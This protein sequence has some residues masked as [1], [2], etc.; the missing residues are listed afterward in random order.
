MNWETG[1]KRGPFT[2]TQIKQLA[3]LMPGL[4][5]GQVQW[6]SGYLTGIGPLL[7]EIESSPEII[8]EIHREFT[9]SKPEPVWILYGTHTGNSERLAKESEKRIAEIGIEARVF[10]MGAF[11]LRDLKNIKRL[12]IIVST[13]GE[14]DPPVQAGDLLEF[15]QSS[16]CPDLSLTSY[17]VLALGDTSYTQFCKTGKDFDGAFEQ[18]GAKRLMDRVDCDVDFEDDYKHWIERVTL[19][20]GQLSVGADGTLVS[21]PNLKPASANGIIFNRKSPF[22]ATVLNKIKLNG[23]HSGKETF[24]L[25]LDMKDSKLQYEPGD[26][27]GIYALNPAKVI[28]PILNLLQF[29]GEEIVNTHQGARR[30]TDALVSDYELRPLTGF[31]LNRYTEITG[32]EKFK[33]II[34]EEASLS[35]YIY[36]RDIYDLLKEEHYRLTPEEFISVLR[37]NTPRMYSIASSQRVVGEE[38]HIVVSAIRYEYCGR[39]KEGHC[40]SFLS[41]R[42]ECGDELK[43]FINPNSRFKLP[44]DPCHSIIMVGAGTG[45]APFRGFIQHREDQG[46]VGKSWLFFGGRNFTTDFLYQTEWLQH[47]KEGTLTRADVAFSRDQKEKIYVQDKML[48][49]GRE[50]FEWLEEGAHFYVCGDKLHM[51]KDVD[52]TLK[53]IIQIYGG[54]TEEKVAEYV[55][56]LLLSDRYQTDVY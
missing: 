40:S 21:Q 1:L 20:L 55:K 3:G 27:L 30:L 16:K 19:S 38:A 35:E 34:G 28:D 23:R 14:G 50:L 24:H 32:S 29:S 41:D 17:C 53:K 18:A 49:H 42:I 45:V 5:M 8:K 11:K 4:D 9:E 52:F 2:E 6:L 46:N 10:N 43:V 36:G 12:L 15:L 56:S 44:S 33:K 31:S 22:T 48:E 37:K 7:Q 13:D 26:A 54:M 47:I 25:E 39:K 51:A